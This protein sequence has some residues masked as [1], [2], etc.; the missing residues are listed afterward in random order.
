[1]AEHFRH[2]YDTPPTWM[3]SSHPASAELITVRPMSYELFFA[4][5]V[6]DN[7]VSYHHRA[8]EAPYR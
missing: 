4:A 7:D 3:M 6:L 8:G 2:L 5:L 1:M